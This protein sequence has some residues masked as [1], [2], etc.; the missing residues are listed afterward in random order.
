MRRKAPFSS[1]PGKRFPRDQI[2]YK[3]FV[4]PADNAVIF[5]AFAIIFR[6]LM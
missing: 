2:S 6:E 4:N 3:Y 5:L 1:L